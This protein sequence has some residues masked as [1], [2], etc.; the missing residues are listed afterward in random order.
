MI[1]FKRGGNC[2]NCLHFLL[3]LLLP[4]SDLTTDKL[5]VSCVAAA[6]AAAAFCLAGP[7]KTPP[8]L[9]WSRAAAVQS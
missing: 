1:N 3:L 4:L 5:I 8:A 9:G 7:K 6:A 2:S